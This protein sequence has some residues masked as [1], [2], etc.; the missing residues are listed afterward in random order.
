MAV[1][2]VSMGFIVLPGASIYVTI[3]VNEAPLS[4]SLVLAPVAL[5]HGTVRPGLSAFSLSDL[6]VYEPL[7]LKSGSVLEHLHFSL[8]SLAESELKLHVVVLKTSKLISLQ[9]HVLV[10]IIGFTRVEVMVVHARTIA[11]LVLRSKSVGEP[12][13]QPST[14]TRLQLHDGG[15]VHFIAGIFTSVLRSIGDLSLFSSITLTA[16]RNV[17]HIY[18]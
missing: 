16:I 5:V 17:S 9:S 12:A 11:F 3:S 10:V 8:L 14:H 4:V 2:T 13:A 1:N 15:N 6:R 7:S 18:F